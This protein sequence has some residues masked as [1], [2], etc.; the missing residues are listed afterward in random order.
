MPAA[1]KQEKVDLTAALRRLLGERASAKLLK[2]C[3]PDLLAQLTAGA[4]A[5]T[6][7]DL[8]VKKVLKLALDPDKSNQWA[9]ELVYERMEGKPA[10]GLAIK[11]DGRKIEERLDDITTEHLNSLAAG[12]ARKEPPDLDGGGEVE[13]DPAGPVARLLDLPGNKP[14]GSER[15][16]KESALA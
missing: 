14:A 13:G 16:A 15:A 3:D 4:Q 8:L 10:P 9:V 7:G 1:G 11:A 6:V 5:P 12:F 2:E